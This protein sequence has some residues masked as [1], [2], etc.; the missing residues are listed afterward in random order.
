M[1]RL[2]LA[3]EP[4]FLGWLEQS[5]PGRLRR[6]EGELQGARK[7]EGNDPDPGTELRGTDDVLRSIAEMFRVFAARYHLDGD[8]PGLDSTQFRT[9]RQKSGQLLM[10]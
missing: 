7:A 10:F 9:P 8:L 4:V 2:P 5:Q 1:L 6:V 3:V